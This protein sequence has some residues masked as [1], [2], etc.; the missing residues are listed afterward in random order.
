MADD[1]GNQLIQKKFLFVGMHGGLKA[2]ISKKEKK[3]PKMAIEI[4]Q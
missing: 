4:L 2:L 3:V 1:K